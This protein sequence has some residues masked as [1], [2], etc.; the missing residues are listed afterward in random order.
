MTVFPTATLWILNIF[1]CGSERVKYIQEK[2]PNFSA[3][4]AKEGVLVGP[5][6][7]KL[8]KDLQFLST[9]TNVEKSKPFF[10]KNSFEVPWQ[11]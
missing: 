10:C 4:K 5:Q 6:I 2:F 1:F 11:H 7:R 8:T 9:M 3:E